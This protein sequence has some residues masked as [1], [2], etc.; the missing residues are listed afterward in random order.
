MPSS[1][2]GVDDIGSLGGRRHPGI[3]GSPKRAFRSN[4]TPGGWGGLYT[5]RGQQ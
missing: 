1:A 2:R 3:A 4:L 5:F